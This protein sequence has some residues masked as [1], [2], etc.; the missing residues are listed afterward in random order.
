MTLYYIILY[1]IILYY[2]IL[3][4]IVLFH[5]MLYHIVYYIVIIH[6][7][8]YNQ[9]YVRCFWLQVKP[10]EALWSDVFVAQFGLW[11][12][13]SRRASTMIFSGLARWRRRTDFSISEAEQI[14]KTTKA[15]HS[16]R[17]VNIHFF[18]LLNHYLEKRKKIR[19]R[20]NPIVG[21]ANEINELLELYTNCH[22]QRVLPE[23]C[24]TNCFWTLG[25][26][27]SSSSWDA[28]AL[29][30]FILQVWRKQLDAEA[31]IP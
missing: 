9:M 27:R 15:S 18:C 13:G 22:K 6:L 3:Y 29:A 4:Y 24:K 21:R 10:L 7:N 11:C 14:E 19:C 28:L 25:D 1:Y 20:P 23:V 8:K 26:E 16:Q 2:I 12:R 17:T 31:S 30:E 5:V